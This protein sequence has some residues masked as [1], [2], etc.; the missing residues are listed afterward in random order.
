MTMQDTH[1]APSWLDTPV[2][3]RRLYAFL[4]LAVVVI[5]ALAVWAASS[6]DDPPP[7]ENS[8][9]LISNDVGTVECTINLEDTRS[10]HIC[11]FMAELD[12]SV[13][14]A[15]HDRSM[16]TIPAT[17]EVLTSS[18]RVEAPSCN[19]PF[20]R[21]DMIADRMENHLREEGAPFSV[22]ETTLGP[23]IISVAFVSPL[24]DVEYTDALLALVTAFTYVEVCDFES[25]S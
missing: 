7:I 9:Q 10:K 16:K 1:Q 3:K 11:S 6:N 2:W 19:I 18:I 8:Q 21:H 5:V 12:G 15:E 14:I 24:T 25:T 13:K 20:E 4:G 23:N 17:G 22:Y